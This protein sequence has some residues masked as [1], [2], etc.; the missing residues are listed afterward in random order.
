MFVKIIEKNAVRVNLQCRYRSRINVGSETF[1]ISE[2][3]QKKMLQFGLKVATKIEEDEELK[4]PGSRQFQQAAAEITQQI[5]EF[6]TRPP[7]QV[8][9]TEF[10]FP[11]SRNVRQ[12]IG[13]GVTAN[14]VMSFHNDIGLAEPEEEDV[15]DREEEIVQTRV[16]KLTLQFFAFL[17]T[18]QPYLPFLPHE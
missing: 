11:E 2:K 17:G 7:A 15:Q 4:N 18:R 5:I 9:V 1:G 14:I 16:F 12:D 6:S 3:P 10:I 8:L 13:Q